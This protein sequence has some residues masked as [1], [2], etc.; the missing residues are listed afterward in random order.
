[1]T[2]KYFAYVVVS[3][4]AGPYDA[5]ASGN[6]CPFL[7]EYCGGQLSRWPAANRIQVSRY[8]A[9]RHDAQNSKARIAKGVTTLIVLIV[10]GFRLTSR[11]A[12]DAGGGPDHR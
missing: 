10:V 12:Y 4:K 7:R 9:A 5:I 8:G 11:W 2:S 6:R 1:M 3:V